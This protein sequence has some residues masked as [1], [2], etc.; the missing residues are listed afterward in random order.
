LDKK[1]RL[2]R[3]N[4]TALSYSYEEIPHLIINQYLGGKGLASYYFSQEVAPG[5]DPL[6]EQNKLFIAPGVFSGTPVPAASRFHTVTK[7]PLTKIYLDCSSGGHFGS[8]LAACNVALLVIEGRSSKLSGIEIA[9]EKVLFHDARNLKGKGIYEVEKEIRTKLKEIQSRILSIGLAGENLVRY[10]CMGNDFSRHV[11]RG[12]SGA[13][14]GSKNVKFIAVRGI[15]DVVAAK[16][17]EFME[18]IE[19]TNKWISSNPWVAG[20]RA[21]GTASNVKAMSK[22]GILPAWNFS[23]EAFE[24]NHLIDHEAL[25]PKIAKR[26]SC[27]ICPV[28]CSKGFN[29]NTYTKGEVEGPEYE[30]LALLGSN[31]GLDDLDAIGALNYLC[32]QHGLDTISTGAILGMVF[33]ALREGALNYEA[34]GLDKNDSLTKQAMTLIEYIA[35]Q[36]GIGKILSQGSRATAK[37]LNMEGSAPEVKNL[38]IAGY[39]PRSSAGMALAYQTSDRGACHLR[40][41]PIGRELSGVLT[42]G[43]STEG[44][45]QFVATQQNAKAAQECFGICQFPYGIGI[46]SP[47]I[48]ELLNNFRGVSYS[49]E[50]IIEIGERIWNLSRIYNCMEGISRKDDYLPKK[51][52]ETTIKYGPNPGRSVTFSMQDKMLDEYYTIRNWD[53]D[54]KPS[55]E[56]LAELDL[57]AVAKNLGYLV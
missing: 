12:G 13:V 42:E 8:E 15:S 46:N 30:T 57:T 43:N 19:K 50:N 21:Y 14:L 52:S 37:Y 54:G 41:F 18:T 25:E 33:E 16:P 23:G 1:Y 10:A 27:A 47:L 35:N 24:N 5:I 51:I 20:S 56:K 48:A 4:L 7:S 31:I 6:S 29:D 2:L 36:Q 28:S 55:T 26:L 32:N 9:S 11:G 44:K 49:V 40:S 22:V 34:I 17:L 45:A 38:D 3:I 39:D 53:S